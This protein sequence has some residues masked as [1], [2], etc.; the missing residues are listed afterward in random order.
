MVTYCV[1]WRKSTEDLNS[2]IFQTK[3]DRL[4]MQSKCAVCVIKKSGF[5]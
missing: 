1:E 2:R 3:N 4:I 5:V